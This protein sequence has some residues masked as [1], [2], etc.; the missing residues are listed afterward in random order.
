MS[1]KWSY[2]ISC[3]TIYVLLD[4]NMLQMLKKYPLSN[5][6]NDNRQNK[7]LYSICDRLRIQIAVTTLRPYLQSANISYSMQKRLLFKM[8]YV[9][10]ISWGG[11]RGEQGHFWPAVY[12]FLSIKFNVAL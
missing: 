10:K 5:Q 3:F 11:G 6:N 8:D 7:E 12:T 2:K 9:C 4:A 1:Q